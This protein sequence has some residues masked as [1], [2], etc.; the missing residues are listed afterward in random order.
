MSLQKLSDSQNGALKRL[1][2]KLQVAA[3][4]GN[5][6]AAKDLIQDIKTLLRPHGYETRLMQAKN[7]LYEASIEA[8]DYP[9][10]IEGLKIIKQKTNKN[11]RV[12][13]EATA[14]LAIAHLRSN[15]IDKAE[16]FV[17]EVLTNDKVIKSEKKRTEFRKSII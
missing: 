15:A 4:N 5:L 10:A 17:K 12:H 13:L 1:E 9:L 14:L 16:P 11:T 8:G 3:Y 2:T 6:K 7:W